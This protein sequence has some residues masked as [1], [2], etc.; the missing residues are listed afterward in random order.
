V[1]EVRAHLAKQ[2]VVVSRSRIEEAGRLSGFLYE[3]RLELDEYLAQQRMAIEECVRVL[4]NRG[5]I[6]PRL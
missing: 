4:G 2:G 1:E 3:D 6:C 5:S